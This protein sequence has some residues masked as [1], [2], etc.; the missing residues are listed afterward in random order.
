MASIMSASEAI[1]WHSEVPD[2]TPVPGH[3]LQ[4]SVAL[5]QKSSGL[6]L[7]LVRQNSCQHGPGITSQS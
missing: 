6:L 4:R 2:I 1:T 7:S 3:T 5:L